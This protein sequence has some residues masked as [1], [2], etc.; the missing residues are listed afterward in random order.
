MYALWKVS[1]VYEQDL[2][3]PST[4]FGTIVAQSKLTIVPNFDQNLIMMMMTRLTLRHE[5]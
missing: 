1:N 5:I 4:L 3:K 2:Q